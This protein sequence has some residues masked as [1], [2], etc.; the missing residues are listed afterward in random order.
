M[1][2]F[3]SFVWSQIGFCLINVNFITQFSTFCI[4]G[5]QEINRN[6]EFQEI[7]AQRTLTEIPHY[8]IN[9]FATV[10]SI[11]LVFKAA[12]RIKKVPWTV[13]TFF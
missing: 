4:Y 7:V 3:W 12:L 10:E 13:T 11:V 1:L 8:G 9:K 2:Y 5:F 6:K